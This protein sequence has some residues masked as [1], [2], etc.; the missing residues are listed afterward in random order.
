MCS[1]STF[2]KHIGIKFF[3]LY[4]PWKISFRK[5]SLMN[6]Y[7]YYYPRRQKG[8]KRKNEDTADRDTPSSK[9]IESLWGHQFTMQVWLETG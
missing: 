4:L 7:R 3:D 2:F 6:V 1:E 5:Y 8:V 9:S